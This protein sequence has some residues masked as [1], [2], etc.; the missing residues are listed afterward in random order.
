ML[1]QAYVTLHITHCADVIH[2]I[3]SF[4]SSFTTPSEKLIQ[5]PRRD[6]IASAPRV[7]PTSVNSI[8]QTEMQPR[9]SSV[10]SSSPLP[11]PLP[12]LLVVLVVLMVLL[13]VPSY[14]AALDC[15][16]VRVDGRSWNLDALGGR[17][18]VVHAEDHP[19]VVKNTTFVFDLCKPLERSKCPRGTN[20][21]FFLLFF[22][23]HA[24]LRE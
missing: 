5:K 12:L 2:Q 11:L 19:P 22:D 24:A 3:S 14:A 13:P 15:H 23:F 17:H 4:V 20:G 18:A 21:N 16:N 1:S 9:V 7:E 10:I 6:E 8:P